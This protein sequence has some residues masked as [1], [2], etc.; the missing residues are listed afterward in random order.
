MTGRSPSGRNSQ[1]VA[2]SGRFI[3]VSVADNVWPPMLI[4][5]RENTLVM[6]VAGMNGYT[7]ANKSIIK[8]SSSFWRMVLFSVIEDSPVEE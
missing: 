8:P 4:F 7:E 1:R 2:E 5:I 3:A 6:N